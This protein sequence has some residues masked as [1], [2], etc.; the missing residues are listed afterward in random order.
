MGGTSGAATDPCSKA[1]P[2]RSHAASPPPAPAVGPPQLPS[3]RIAPSPTSRGRGTPGSQPPRYLC[4]GRLIWPPVLTPAWPP[5]G[6]SRVAASR[7]AVPRP[8]SLQRHPAGPNRHP[9]RQ[10]ERAP[11]PFCTSRC[12]STRHRAAA[13]AAAS[14]YPLLDPRAIP[15]LLPGPSQDSA[16]ARPAP[17]YLART[18]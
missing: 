15:S 16:H 14:L 7:L 2:G 4:L 12:S 3:H 10:P 8:A 11:A 13:A 18:H 17:S 9:A 6:L 5:G 1:E